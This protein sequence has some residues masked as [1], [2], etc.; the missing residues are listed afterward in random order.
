[1]TVSNSAPVGVNG[2]TIQVLRYRQSGA[3]TVSVT[4]ATARNGT[5]FNALTRVI[6]IRSTVDCFIEQGDVTIEATATDHFL[7][8]EETR[9]VALGGDNPGIAQYTHIAAIRSSSDGTLY[10]SEME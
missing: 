9:L 7:P 1:M 6:E 5:A 3:Q 10:V 2:E 4:N 8:A